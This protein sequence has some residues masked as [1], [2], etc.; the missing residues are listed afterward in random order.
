MSKVTVKAFT[1]SLDGFGAGMNQTLE[2]PMGERGHELHPWMLHTR[3]FHR[4]TGKEGGTTGID[5]D[6]AEKSMENLGAWIMGRNMFAPANGPWPDY[7]WKG[8]WGPNPPYH[9][10]VYVLTHKAREPLEMEGGTTFY[11][12]TDG[13]HAAMEQAQKVANGK[14]IRIGGGTSTVRQ[15][16]QAGYIDEL[17]LVVSPVFLGA[18]EHLF[19]GIDMVALG[20]TQVEKIEGEKGTHI[21]VRK[22]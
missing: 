17:H 19:S 5:N 2:K 6:F 12:V 22:K 14:D 20:F 10:P 1:I 8:W 3:M 11:F 21:V 15:Y 13:I 9:C 16:L 18:G 4:M 7:E